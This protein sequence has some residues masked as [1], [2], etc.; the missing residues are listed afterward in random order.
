M[1]FDQGRVVQAGFLRGRGRAVR[2]APAVGNVELQVSPTSVWLLAL[3]SRQE[4]TP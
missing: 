2:G 1:Q 4:L 3:V